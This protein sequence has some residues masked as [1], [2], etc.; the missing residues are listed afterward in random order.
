MAYRQA[1]ADLDTRVNAQAAEVDMSIHVTPGPRSILRDVV[2]EGGDADNPRVGRAIVLER[3]APL[4]PAA[5]SETRRRLFDLAEY[6][7]VDINVQPV[8]SSTAPPANAPAEQAVVARIALEERPRYRLRYGLA[9]SDDVV[10]DQRDQRLGFA[11]DLDN[12]NLF[13]RGAIA[14]ASL[15]LR[16]DQQAGRVTIGANRLFSLPI[17]STAFV[18][19]ERLLQDPDGAFPIT[20][21]ITSLTTE[22]AYRIRPSIDVRYGY[23]IEKNH[24]FIR[25]EEADAFDLTVKVARFTT[26]GLVDRRDDAFNPARGWFTSSTLEFSTPGIGSDLKFLKNFAQYSHYIRVARGLVLASAA[27][28]GLARTFGDEVLIPSERFYAGGANTVRGYRE[29]ALGAQS[30]LGGAEGGSALVVVNGELRFPVYRWLKGVGFV[31]LG[32]V[33][34][35]VSDISFTDFQIGIGAGARIDTPLGLIRFDLGVPANPRSFDPRW[36]FHFGLGH[37]F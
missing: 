34:P 18:E 7:S 6:R 37:A 21:D 35:K 28:V 14:G 12:R 20:S 11:A 2:V 27:R 22:Q 25:S 1:I 13:G 16:T 29:D 36:R 19:R 5:I 15:R 24:T 31:D 26:S 33:Y 8:D 9:I 32:N 30:V 17:R 4:D 23:G 3:N 10:G